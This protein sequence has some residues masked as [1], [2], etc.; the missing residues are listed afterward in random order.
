MIDT[1]IG[2][3]HQHGAWANIRPKR[4]RKE[5]SCFSPSLFGVWQ[6][7]TTNS[8]PTTSQFIQPASELDPEILKLADQRLG[9][10]QIA[11][12]LQPPLVQQCLQP[13]H[14]G[15]LRDTAGHPVAH[16]G[17]SGSD[18]HA[19]RRNA[20][21]DEHVEN[22]PPDAGEIDDELSSS[23]QSSRPTWATIPG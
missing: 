2:R 15:K 20:G 4:N 10:G 11:Q 5:P 19:E 22:R 18:Q 12:N 9:L 17:G 6:P 13:A 16:L 7:A 23:R 1:S 8:Q 3:A 21:I 14:Q